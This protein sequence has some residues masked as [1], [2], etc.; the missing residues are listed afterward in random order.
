MDGSTNVSMDVIMNVNKRFFSYPQKYM[1]AHTNTPHTR[2]RA[3]TRIYYILFVVFLRLSRTTLQIATLCRMQ[4][5]SHAMQE[6]CQTNCSRTSQRPGQLQ[7]GSFSSQMHGIGIAH[8]SMN[9]KE[10]CYREEGGGEGG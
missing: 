8:V 6:S 3:H 7:V 5:R 9:S 1:H 10:E 2:A 4:F